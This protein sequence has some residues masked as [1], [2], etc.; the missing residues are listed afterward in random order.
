[1]KFISNHNIKQLSNLGVVSKQLLNPENSKSTRVAITEV[2]LEKGACQ[3]KHIHE[4]SEQ[5]WYA[6]KGS[7]QLLLANDEI[8][9]FQVGNVVRFAD[10][11][12]HGLL[13]N[14]NDEFIYISVTSPPINFSYTYENKI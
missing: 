3:P 11:D 14:S 6:V 12:V 1:M 2:H 8:K 10:G 4:S 13:N 5:I 7:G 9:A